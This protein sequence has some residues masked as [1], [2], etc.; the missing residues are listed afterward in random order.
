M[1][2]WAGSFVGVAQFA[3]IFAGTFHYYCW[4]IMEPVCYLM[5]FANFT[6]G[7]AFYLKIEEELEMD[8]LSQILT[9]RFTLKACK[10]QGID[11][12]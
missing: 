11:L 9:N 4:D 1:V 3:F 7:F 2:L 6:T 8:N 10:N 5:T 12:I